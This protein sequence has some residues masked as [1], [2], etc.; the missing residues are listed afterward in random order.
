MFLAAY[1]GPSMNPTLREPEIM[2]VIPYDNRP[3]RVGDVAFFLP[4]NTNQP[5]VHRITRVTPA[6]I[7]TLGDNNIH[8][9]AL[10]LH[11]NSIKGRVVAAWHGQKRRKISGGLLGR[12]ASRWFRLV[13]SLDHGVSPLLHPVYTAMSHRGLIARLLPARFRPRVIAFN[14]RGREQFQLLLGKRIIGRY[15][16]RRQQWQ[17]QRPFQLLVDSTT[18]PKNRG[19]VRST[20]QV[21]TERQPAMDTQGRQYTIVLADGTHWEI[22]ACDNEAASIVA[23]L[24]SAMKLSATT[25][26]SGIPDRNNLRRLFVQVDAHTSMA[27]CY[28]PLASDND[29]VACV[30]SPCDHWG[31]PHVNLVRLSLIF[32]REA[33]AR[34]GFL[35]HGALAERDGLGVILA[36]P[37]GTG[38]TTASNRL[39]PPWRSL[40]DDTTLVVRDQQGIYRAHPWPTWSRFLDGGAGGTWDVQS[41]VALKSIFILA[42]AAEDR[43]DRVGPG[44]AVSLLVE[45]VRQASMFMPLGL[46]KEEMRGL[47]LERFNN[48]CALAQVVPA[49]MLNI[50][51]TG[52]F[53]HEI[54][55]ALEAVRGEKTI[56]RNQPESRPWSAG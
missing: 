33:Q 18:L 28:V 23:Q 44:Q 7:S 41:S 54:D 42:Q 47:N 49:H 52:P 22:T 27:D 40:C 25:G 43:V 32:A 24:G 1:V 37:G 2:E 11:A 56:S 6:G 19:K 36:A 39:Q 38:K 55:Q 17:I 20:R 30:L 45:S 48:L 35:I 12:L 3:L 5:V 26:S 50:S 15:D 4:P 10:L 13:R 21:L 34:G 29:T 31:G 51:L 46:F 9:D 16:D 53:W 14:T 8:E